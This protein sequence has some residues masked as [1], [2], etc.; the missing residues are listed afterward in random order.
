MVKDP[1]EAAKWYRKAADQGNAHGQANLGRMYANGWGVPK[2]RKE[3]IK[4]LTKAS[5]QGNEYAKKELSKLTSTSPEPGSQGQP[6]DE[7]ERLEKIRLEAPAK[8]QEKERNEAAKTRGSI[9]SNLQNIAEF[10]DQEKKKMKSRYGCWA[11]NIEKGNS[12]W[13]Q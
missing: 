13:A 2:D 12:G 3:A 9:R 5:D 8:Q 6:A 1:D 4:W 11:G 7:K 10:W